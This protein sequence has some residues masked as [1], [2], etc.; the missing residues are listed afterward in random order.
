MNLT[1][2]RI[3]TELLSECDSILNW[4]AVNTPHLKFNMYHTVPYLGVLS[5]T[6]NSYYCALPNQALKV[7]VETVTRAVLP[8]HKDVYNDVGDRQRLSHCVLNCES[9]PIDITV[10]GVLLVLQPLHWFLLNSQ[11]PHGAV[12]EPPHSVICV[13]SFRSYSDYAELLGLS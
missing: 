5:D 13:D 10:G 4:C 11:T 3:P 12:C 7:T 9:K 6:F 8:T 1:Q 2:T